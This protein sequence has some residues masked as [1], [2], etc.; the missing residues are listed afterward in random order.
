MSRIHGW[1]LML[2]LVA[3]AASADV[4]ELRDGRQLEGRLTGANEDAIRFETANGVV[5]IRKSEAAALRFGP[6]DAKPGGPGASE[7][8]AG[9]ADVAAQKISI[10]AGTRLRV[11]VRDT[12]DPRQSAKGDRFSALL[13]TPIAAEG[14]AVVPAQTV[15]YGT[16]TQASPT[17]PLLQQLR[18]EL[19]EL[20]IQGR[21]VAI[22]TGPHSRLAEPPGDDV[23]ANA[24]ETSTARVPAGALLEFRLLQPLE[25]EV[26]VA[27]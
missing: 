14:H 21:P 20:Q 1:L 3:A 5:T 19:E 7:K 10:P 9:R 23:P 16:I 17:G 22:V 24:A 13:A 4:L 25:L 27:R 11:R 26:R 8:R 18:L 6:T 15:V 12:L 2:V